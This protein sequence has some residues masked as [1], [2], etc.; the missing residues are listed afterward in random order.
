MDLKRK[1]HLLSKHL[2]QF[3]WKNIKRLLLIRGL[4]YIWQY[5]SGPNYQVW[6]LQMII[7]FW[8]NWFKRAYLD[9]YFELCYLRGAKYFWLKCNFR[10]V[11]LDL[12]LTSNLLLKFYVIFYLWF[13]FNKLIYILICEFSVM[14]TMSNTLIN[15]NRGL[16]TYYGR[17]SLG[18]T[19]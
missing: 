9:N 2:L 16:F 1:N 5:G 10:K 4:L 11:K 19:P 7:S 13:C 18:V 3:F 6:A 12:F 17:Q 15:R 14:K 8:M